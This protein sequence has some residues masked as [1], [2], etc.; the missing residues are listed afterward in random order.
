MDIRGNCLLNVLVV[1]YEYPP[2]G[3]GAASASRELAQAISKAG[4]QVMVLTSRTPTRFG[5]EKDGPVN[6]RRIGALRRREDRSNIFEMFSFLIVG[7]FSINKIVIENNIDGI[8]CFFSVPSGPIGIVANKRL[9]KPYIVSLRGGDVPGLVP[10]LDILHRLIGGFRRKILRQ[11]IA[12]VANSRDLAKRSVERDLVPVEIIPNGVDTEFFCPATQSRDHWAIEK[13]LLFV[14]RLHK[15]KNLS[16]LIRVLGFAKDRNLFRFRLTIVGDG[17]ERAKLTELVDENKLTSQIKFCGWKD[18][19]A[20]REKMRES[21]CL[22]NYSL[23]EGLPN[24]VLEAMASSLPVICSDIGPHRELISNG[25][26]GFLLGFNDPKATAAVLSEII[27]DKENLRRVAG[28]GREWVVKEFQW[29][30]VAYQYLQ[31]FESRKN[32]PL[33]DIPGKEK[34]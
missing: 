31:L 22:I 20:I 4:H 34:I 18:A 8:I 15:Q 10:E 25:V 27:A 16:S 19:V 23:Y 24:I 5:A 3:G 17:P 30:E 33:L 12:V 13:E 29:S 28:Q 26:T 11:A 32:R 14:G 21:D 9:G 1:N 2:I 7:L 6:V